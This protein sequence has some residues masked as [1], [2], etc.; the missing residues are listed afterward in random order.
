MLTSDKLLMAGQ[1]GDTVGIAWDLAT[2]SN[3]S[4]DSATSQFGFDADSLQYSRGGNYQYR[5]ADVTTNTLVYSQI[6]FSPWDLRNRDDQNEFGSWVIPGYTQLT[7]KQDGYSF[8]LSGYSGN[9]FTMTKLETPFQWESEFGNITQTYS[10]D[11]GT[12]LFGG[13]HVSYDGTEIIV[14]TD[15]KFHKIT[16]TT[17]YDLSTA[18]LTQTSAANVVARV[19]SVQVR[20]DGKKIVTSDA[21]FTYANN[22]PTFYQYDLSTAWDLSTISLDVTKTITTPTTADLMTALYFSD[23]ERYFIFHTKQSAGVPFTD[24]L[25]HY[26]EHTY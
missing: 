12:S 21:F 22:V 6:L 10:V 19:G 14:N 17:P 23:S 8:F 16:M 4:I 3:T 5:V 2:V 15:T 13:S 1:S 18:S 25:N 11:L 24:G 9:S 26:Y 7:W 20:S